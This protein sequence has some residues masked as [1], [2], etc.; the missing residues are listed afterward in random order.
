MVAKGVKTSIFLNS[1]ILFCAH[2]HEPIL[3]N[4]RHSTKNVFVFNVQ[5]FEKSQSVSTFFGTFSDRPTTPTP[6]QKW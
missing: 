5:F 4:K 1:L 2:V 3:M 6:H